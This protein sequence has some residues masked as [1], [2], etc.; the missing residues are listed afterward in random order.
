MSII[1]ERL[2]PVAG[3][4]RNCPDIFISR[5]GQVSVKKEKAADCSAA[6]P[7][8]EERKNEKEKEVIYLY[9]KGNM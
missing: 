6:L 4:F 5:C 2:I 3:C 9:N 7:K 1:G 8:K